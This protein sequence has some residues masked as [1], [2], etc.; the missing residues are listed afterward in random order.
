MKGTAMA[1]YVIST[2][3]TFDL[4]KEQ[5]EKR[6]I[7]YINFHYTKDGVKFE[8]DLYESTAYGTVTVVVPVFAREL[9]VKATDFFPFVVV[10]L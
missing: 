4:T 2:C 10:T 5:A 1:N 3:S 8:D 9:K 6:N 7:R